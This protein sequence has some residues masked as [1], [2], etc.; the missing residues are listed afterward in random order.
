MVA[1]VFTHWTTIPGV[2]IAATLAGRC[3]VS[4]RPIIS[5]RIAPAAECRPEPPLA[6]ISTAPPIPI[7]AATIVRRANIVFLL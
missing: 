4:R 2:P 1:D 3:R 5:G 6:E 7:A